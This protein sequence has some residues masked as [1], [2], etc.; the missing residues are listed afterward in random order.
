MRRVIEDAPNGF[1]GGL[2]G[3]ELVGLANLV[4]DRPR[5]IVL[6]HALGGLRAC[7]LLHRG[8][9]AGPLASIEQILVVEGPEPRM[10]GAVRLA[11]RR[12]ARY[13]I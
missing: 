11:K 8:D 9:V 3:P 13:E 1:A 4:I 5:N 2:S 12:I 10:P 6:N 7:L